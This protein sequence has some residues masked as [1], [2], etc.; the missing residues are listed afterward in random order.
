MLQAILHATLTDRRPPL[1]RPAPRSTTLLRKQFAQEQ[2]SAAFWRSQYFILLNKRNTEKLALARALA[3][4]EPYTCTF[5]QLQ[6]A[7]A[8]LRNCLVQAHTLIRQATFAPSG[9]VHQCA[10]CLGYGGDHHLECPADLF[11][12]GQ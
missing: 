11:L 3:I 4:E 5:E 7:A 12:R 1:L 10:W 8:G 6:Q 9:L 2:Q